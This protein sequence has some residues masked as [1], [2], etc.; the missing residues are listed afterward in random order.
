MINGKMTSIMFPILLVMWGLFQAFKKAWK[1]V[2]SSG[3]AVLVVPQDNNY[4]LKP[5]RF[6][7]PCKSNIAV[8]VLL[9]KA[10]DYLVPHF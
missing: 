6:S 5:I 7:G 10:S 3:D 8:Q 4:L 1:E 2:C 9:S